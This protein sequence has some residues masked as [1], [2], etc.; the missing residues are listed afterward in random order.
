M[1]KRFVIH[2]IKSISYYASH[3]L[4]IAMFAAWPVYASANFK[5][6]PDSLICSFA[7]A[8]KNGV[9]VWST[10]QKIYVKEAK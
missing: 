1:I 6:E 10:Y 7:T 3:L 5:N 2:N 9:K 4:L 8:T